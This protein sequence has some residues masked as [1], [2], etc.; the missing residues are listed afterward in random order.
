MRLQLTDLSREAYQTISSAGTDF[1]YAVDYLQSGIQIREFM[2]SLQ[3]IHPKPDL[4]VRLICG[5]LVANPTAERASIVKKIQ[6]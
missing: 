4:K 2:P 5:F 6:N 1:L 3:E